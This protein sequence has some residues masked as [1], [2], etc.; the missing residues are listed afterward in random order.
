[1][2][3]ALRWYAEGFA[4]RS[5]VRV[6]LAL[7]D[8]LERLPQD[9]ETTLFRVVQEALINI[10]R[11]AGSPTA[12]IR[13][14]ADPAR[15]TLEIEDAGRG[16]TPDFVARLMRGVG[17]IGVGLAGMRERLQQLGGTLDIDSTEKGTIVRA[18]IPMGDVV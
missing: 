10:H 18:Q 1:M 4:D 2:L 6:E 11:H 16:M 15:L 13:L 9:V 14:R 17:A 3:S 8:A 5:G 7:P 12:R